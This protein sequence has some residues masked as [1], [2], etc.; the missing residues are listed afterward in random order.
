METATSIT[1][2]VMNIGHGIRHGDNRLD[3]INGLG[4]GGIG[5]DLDSTLIGIHKR[6]MTSPRGRENP[7]VLPDEHWR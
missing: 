4:G 3:G 7:H 1:K 5:K 6:R 2:Y